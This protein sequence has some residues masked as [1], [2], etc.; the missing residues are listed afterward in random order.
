MS[1]NH[2][3]LNNDFPQNVEVDELKVNGDLI[4]DGIKQP[5]IN[6]FSPNVNLLGT[7]G[8]PTL[9]SVL[10]FYN[11]V[12]NLVSMYLK[13]NFRCDLNG[14]KITILMDLPD[15]ITK[16]SAGPSTEVYVMGNTVP[17]PSIQVE[18][19]L[20]VVYSAI[21]TGGPNNTLQLELQG[22]GA[23]I[24]STPTYLAT[25]NVVYEIAE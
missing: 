5:T 15:L 7:A 23:A 14:N 13:I 2:L 21:T 20:Y 12:G 9:N 8:P 17:D 6:S 10:G 4:V 25:L 24:W 19:P 11:R 1:I 22:R 18:E 3:M 16:T